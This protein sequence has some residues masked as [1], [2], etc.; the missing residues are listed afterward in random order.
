VREEQGHHL[1]K[2]GRSRF[3]VISKKGGRRLP[4]ERATSRDI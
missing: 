3:E 4:R 2:E 1:R